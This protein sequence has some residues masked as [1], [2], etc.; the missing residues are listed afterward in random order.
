M[1]WLRRCPA[2]RGFTKYDAGLRA[3][4]ADGPNEDTNTLHWQR[5]RADA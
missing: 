4:L 1:R 2:R 5:A 3:V